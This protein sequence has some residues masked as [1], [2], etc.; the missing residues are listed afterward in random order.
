MDLP[1]SQESLGVLVNQLPGMV[2]RCRCDNQWT[3]LFVSEGV[4]E[5]T[6]YQP[7]QLIG[8]REISFAELIHPDDRQQ[9]EDEVKTACDSSA[10]YQLSYRL[11]TAD[12]TLK[13]VWEQGIAIPG[14]DG[15]SLVLEGYISDISRQKWFELELKTIGDEHTAILNSTSEGIYGMDS[16]GACTFINRAACAMLG[17]QPADII[18]RDMHGVIHHHH[19]DGS[20]YEREDCP[21]FRAVTGAKV[22]NGEETLFWTRGGNP[23]EVSCS[24]QP[25]QKAQG[26]TRAVVT[27]N[28]ISE[29]KRQREQLRLSEERFRYAAEATADAIWDWDLAT[30][31]LWWNNGLFSLFGYRPGEIEPVSG[32]W[33]NRIHQDDRESVLSSIH[34][35]IDGENVHWE[36]QYR[37]LARNGD[38]LQVWD[39]G[40]VIRDLQGKALRMIGG[41]TDITREQ[42]LQERMEQSQRLEA[43]GL[44]TG[45]VA[46][47]FNNLL[48]VIIG[49]NQLLEEALPGEPRLQSMANMA[50]AAAQRG[51]D[52]TQRLLA[53]ARRQPL[54]PQSVDINTLVSNMD[55]LL[56]HT[57]KE[58]IETELVRGES[59]WKARVDPSQLEDALLNLA[60]NAGDAM[61]EGGKLTI[62]TAN[63]VLDQDYTDKHDDV[64]PGMYVMIAVSDTGKGIPAHILSQVFDPFFTTK[65]AGKGTGLGLSMVYGFVKQSGGHIKIYSEEGEG[66]TVRIYLPQAEGESGGKAVEPPPDALG[67]GHEIILLVEDDELVRTHVE[68]LLKA[69][70]YV[71]LTAPTGAEA[72]KVLQKDTAID[73]LFTDVIM[74]GGL[75]GRQLAEAALALRPGLKVLYTSG[76]TENAIVHHGHLDQ[77]V[78]LLSKP[79]RRG[80]LALKVRSVLDGV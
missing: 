49:N 47:D 13:W 73:L 58:D 35:V 80:D 6:G 14:G 43:L 50:L 79:F 36:H 1:L 72:L 17:Y 61:P 18:G 42:K 33:S 45:G 57:L 77:G 64:S 25:I 48:T 46:H 31:H 68:N 75:N 55:A 67:R 24:V 56:R 7:Q 76:Y 54:E 21:L 28:D 78:H 30:D 23:L 52:L 27:F 65:P 19:A 34:D 11:I 69:L 10:R 74:P 38:Y 9:V 41:M 39:R 40:F 60:L 5:L 59:L 3:M 32:F 8:N 63:R 26:Y 44:L 16:T 53:F 51:A 22:L 4:L 70:G 12:G 71:V 29:Q 15:E 66:T 37:F 2:Y 20:G 62:E